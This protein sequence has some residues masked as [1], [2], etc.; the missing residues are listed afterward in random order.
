MCVIMITTVFNCFKLT[1]FLVLLCILKSDLIFVSCYC[2]YWA[3]FIF[4][5]LVNFTIL[6]RANDKLDFLFAGD[7]Q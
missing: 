3:I 4:L 2:I 5:R 1:K 7:N 6:P